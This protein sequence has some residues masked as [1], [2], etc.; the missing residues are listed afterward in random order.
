MRRITFVFLLSFNGLLN[1]QEQFLDTVKLGEVT[2][3]APTERKIGEDPIS[4]ELIQSNSY[5]NAGELL[6]RHSPVFIKSYGIGSLSTASF[7]GTGAAHTQVLWNNL[8]VNSSM[9]G[10][11]DLAL[12]PSFFVD[13][14][15]VLTGEAANELSNGAL[16]GA[17]NM[18]SKL[19]KEKSISVRQSIASFQS[20]D[21]RL[22]WKSHFKR[23]RWQGKFLR[24]SAL[25]NFKYRDIAQLGF[26][27]TRLKNAALNQWGFD[28][29]LNFQIDD[30]QQLKAEVWYLNT[31]RNL[32]SIFT[33][34][35]V[36]ESQED[37]SIR[38][39]FEYEKIKEKYQFSWANSYSIDDLDYYNEIADIHSKSN[40]NT[41]QT[42]LFYQRSW[43][44]GFRYQIR[45]NYSHATANQMAYSNELIQ[46]RIASHLKVHKKIGKQIIWD[47]FL[48]H[49]NVLDEANYLMPGSGINFKPSKWAN[50]EFNV[51]A[52][53]NVK[54]PSLND[55]YWNPGG[56]PNL[57]AEQSFQY[58]L[59][60]N[61]ELINDK[62][63]I[64]W[65]RSWQLF[66]HQIENYIQWRPTVFGYWEAINLDAV[67]AE[68]IEVKEE[69]VKTIKSTEVKLLFNYTYTQSEGI[70]K[71]HEFDQSEGKQLIYI[72]KHQ[73]NL[74]AKAKRR[75]WNC[76]VQ[77]QLISE[78]YL[79][80]D[81]ADWLPHYQLLDLELGKTWN[82]GK[83]SLS[84]SFGINNAL[85]AEYQAIAWRP[86]PGRNF[87]FSL[88]Y[89]LNYE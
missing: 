82:F 23:W 31:L 42:L 66:S 32:P 75:N 16:G 56:N 68:G 47:V 74:S 37:E 20:F 14:I 61:K 51:S 54:H 24:L 6:Q 53:K 21:T 76:L 40:A 17:L 49:E 25:N 83:Q 13:E 85:D 63:N 67:L 69:V 33:V 55:L 30:N 50:S 29:K 65:N 59:S 1:A 22:A 73:T 19:K 48:N 43:S 36:L 44:K 18:K 46:D 3:K 78:R 38:V 11:V 45:L 27:E 26:P 2:I 35:N 86:M 5:K 10:V 12:I 79:S 4:E 34:N 89:Y 58:S 8:S 62:R 28:Q 71:R 57:M 81:N 41:L 87:A 9:N 84:A 72:P 70:G 64:Q 39:Y 7:R 88:K 15:Q 77:W 52:L 60:W 80:S